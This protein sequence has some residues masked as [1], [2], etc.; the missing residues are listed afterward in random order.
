ML[1]FMPVILLAAAL[2]CGPSKGAQKGTDDSLKS[3]STVVSP[4]TSNRPTK[5]SDPNKGGIPPGKEPSK[6]P[7]KGG[8]LPPR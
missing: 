5:T 6:T 2:G 1:R 4:D 7:G 3:I 8:T